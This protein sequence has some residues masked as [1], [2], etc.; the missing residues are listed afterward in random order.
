M[1]QKSDCCGADIAYYKAKT[2]CMQCTK[3][4]KPAELSDLRNDEYGS[5][6]RATDQE[7]DFRAEYEKR[8][9]KVKP[10]EPREERITF[11]S[12][13][14]IDLVDEGPG[15]YQGIKQDHPGRWPVRLCHE[16]AY[17]SVTTAEISW[18]EIFDCRDYILQLEAR[19]GR[20]EVEKYEAEKEIEILKARLNGRG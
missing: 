20:L 19:A 18:T 13:A 3:E 1:T 11:E 6:I 15:E 17:L 2:W 9:R 10:A 4:C 16:N 5:Y 12:G 8:L 7:T 14:T